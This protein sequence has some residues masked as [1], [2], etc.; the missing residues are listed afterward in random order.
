[1][2]GKKH[3]I[4]NTALLKSSSAIKRKET[5]LTKRATNKRSLLVSDVSFTANKRRVVLEKGKVRTC[6]RIEILDLNRMGKTGV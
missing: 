3:T 1:M 6:D 4:P 2:A 5:L